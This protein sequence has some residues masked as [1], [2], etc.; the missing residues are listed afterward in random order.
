MLAYVDTDQYM[1]S[2]HGGLLAGS[3]KGSINNH[4]VMVQHQMFWL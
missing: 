1:T 3:W 4:D 2:F